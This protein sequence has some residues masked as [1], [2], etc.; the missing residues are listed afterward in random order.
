NAGTLL[1]NNTSGSATGSGA[2]NVNSG[3]ALGGSGFITGNIS[4]ASGGTAAPGSSF[5][6][7]TT[8]NFSL[9]SGATFEVELGT[10]NTS[11]NAG[12]TFDQIALTNSGSVFTVGG[13]T[14][15]VLLVGV[16]LRNAPYRIVDATATGTS[17]TFS[18]FFAG[19]TNGVVYEAGAG[20]KY[21][22][23]ATSSE[24]DVTFTE[25]PEPTA[26]G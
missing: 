10:S 22:V 2:V 4:V 11:A 19:L 5:G 24:I 16:P 21:R 26:V 1:A 23:D 13:A 20:V 12:V 9:S 14:L 8:R 17:V 18:N 15:K 7:L 6:K 25:V 3:G